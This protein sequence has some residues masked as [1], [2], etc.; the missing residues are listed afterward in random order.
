MEGLLYLNDRQATGSFER[1][2][3]MTRAESDE[4]H[5][6]CFIIHCTLEEMLQHPQR[7]A[8]SLVDRF[9]LMFCS[10]KDVRDRIPRKKLMKRTLVLKR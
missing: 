1:E 6:L 3:E 10:R 5:R 7:Y 4:V 2:H 8:L 9:T